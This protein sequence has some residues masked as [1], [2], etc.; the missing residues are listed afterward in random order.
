[1]EK[2]ISIS[3]VQGNIIINIHIRYIIKQIQIYSISIFV[4]RLFSFKY[5]PFLLDEEEKRI[6]GVKKCS[7]PCTGLFSKIFILL[8]LIL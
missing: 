8:L 7:K 6:A 4:V 5:N 1:M 2:R 3:C